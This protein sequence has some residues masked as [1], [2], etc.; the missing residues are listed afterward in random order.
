MHITYMIRKKFNIVWFDRK[1]VEKDF[2]FKIF[3]KS[4]KIFIKYFFSECLFLPAPHP[5]LHFHPHCT[6]TRTIPAPALCLCTLGFVYI[7]W[8]VTYAQFI[9]C[10]AQR[11]Y[12]QKFLEWIYISSGISCIEKSISNLLEDFFPLHGWF[13]ENL[14]WRIQMPSIFDI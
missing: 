4:W 9:A 10:T 14:M 7:L 6:L 1:K 2:F 3:L 13:W 5:H 8:V 11:S 12:S